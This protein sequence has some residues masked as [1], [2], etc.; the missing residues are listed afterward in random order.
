MDHEAMMSQAV[1]RHDRDPGCAG[2]CPTGSPVMVRRGCATASR[3]TCSTGP[4]SS[5]SSAAIT[6][7]CSTR[8]GASTTWPTCRP[9]AIRGARA[10]PGRSPSIDRPAGHARRR[11]ARG[12]LEAERRHRTRRACSGAPTPRACATGRTRSTKPPGTFRDR[13]RG[14]LDRRRLGRQRRAAVRVDPGRGLGQPRA[15]AAS[16]LTVEIINCAVPGHSPGQRWYHFSQVGWPMDPDLVI[17]ESTAADVGWDERRLRY[18]LARGTGLG[19]APFTSRA[20][21]ERGRRAGSAAP[22]STSGPCSP[23]IGRSW[24]G[25][26]RTMAADCRARGVP[27]VWVLFPASAGRTTRADQRGPDRRRHGPPA[28]RASST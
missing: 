24:P 5:G 25:V 19:F 12:R 18:L 21:D 4:T 22:T 7:S 27:I 11:P 10:A 26:Y 2:W 28:S 6:S 23:D 17:Y 1:A 13:A 14:R 16:G 9:C 20:L 15:Q 8:A 3:A